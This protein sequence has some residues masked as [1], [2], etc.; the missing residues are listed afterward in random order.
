MGLNVSNISSFSSGGRQ[1]TFSRDVNITSLEQNVFQQLNA[2]I[3]QD[4]PV[5]PS[6]PNSPVQM[7][8]ISVEDAIK[9][10]EQLE[11]EGKV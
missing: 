2:L 3:P 5:T 6:A 10:L 11:K 9:E 8:H 7:K 1:P 4:T